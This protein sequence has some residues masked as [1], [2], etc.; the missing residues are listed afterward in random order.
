M[1]RYFVGAFAGVLLVAGGLLMWQNTAAAN[2]A[3]PILPIS[4]AAPVP[5]A[6]PDQAVPEPPQASEKTREEKRFSRYDHDKD[7]KV[8][9]DEFL[10]AR[11][12]AFAKLD[13]DGNGQL[14]FEEYAVKGIKRFGD[15]DADRNGSLTATEFAST[16]VQR[17]AHGPRRCPPAPTRNDEDAS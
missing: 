7:G 10:A 12:R 3:R 11:R 5:S 17:T 8:G 13:L 16:R 4:L 9:R 1:W 15:A 6:D 2:H 14:S